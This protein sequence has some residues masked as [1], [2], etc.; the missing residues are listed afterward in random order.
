MWNPQHVTT[1][2]PPWYG[3]IDED[4]GE[5][6]IDPRFLSLDMGFRWVVSFMPRPLYL[7]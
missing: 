4:L 5:R 6:I 3:D 7:L 1:Y 2:R